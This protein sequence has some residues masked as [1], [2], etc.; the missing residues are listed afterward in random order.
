MLSVSGSPFFLVT[1]PFT[2]RVRALSFASFSSGLGCRF[3]RDALP[4]SWEVR[5]FISGLLVTIVLR[6]TR[7]NRSL[8]ELRSSPHQAMPGLHP[9]RIASRVRH[10]GLC[11]RSKRMFV[12][13]GNFKSSF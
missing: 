11:A 10:F 13:G 5:V 1:L 4:R 12:R 2:L 3:F 8:R 6:Q 7:S 9:S